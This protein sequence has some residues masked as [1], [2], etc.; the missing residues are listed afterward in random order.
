MLLKTRYFFE[1]FETFN[2][3]LQTRDVSSLRQGAF[4][5]VRFPYVWASS[6]GQPS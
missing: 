6:A 2:I 4:S 1:V 5:V 3:L